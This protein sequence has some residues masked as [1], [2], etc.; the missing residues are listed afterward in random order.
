MGL[1]CHR[2]LSSVFSGAADARSRATAARRQLT[3]RFPTVAK[4]NESEKR[5]T[6]LFAISPIGACKPLSP[7]GP[8]SSQ[9]GHCASAPT[10][11]HDSLGG[12]GSLLC[13]HTGEGLCLG[14]NWF[15]AFP[16]EPVRGLKAHGKT[17]RQCRN[18]FYEGVRALAS[19]NEA[20][21]SQHLRWIDAI[22]APEELG[23]LRRT[24]KAILGGN[25]GKGLRLA[26]AQHL[27]SRLFQSG[28]LQYPHRGRAPEP[29]KRNL[30]RANTATGCFGDFRDG[31][32]RADVSAHE[33]L[34]PAHIARSRSRFLPLQSLGVAVRQT[35]QQTQC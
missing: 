24:A 15:P 7:R 21:V 8:R 13:R 25:P 17:R 6:N 19:E 31:Q 5:K 4:K 2:R 20:P 30:Q 10:H 11:S 1:D 14:Q 22:P 23:K 27:R 29:M 18:E 28:L 9:A 26:G 33:R 34:G 35:E 32:R 16:T 12:G 3:L